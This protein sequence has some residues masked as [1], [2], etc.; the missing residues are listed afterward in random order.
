MQTET[1]KDPKEVAPDK[2][3]ARPDALVAV[4]DENTSSDFP[5][6]AAVGEI[7]HA[8]TAHSP[9]YSNAEQSESNTIDIVFTGC[10]VRV[11][12]DAIQLW[13]WEDRGEDQ[14]IT[15]D[16]VIPLKSPE[17]PDVITVDMS[18]ILEPVSLDIY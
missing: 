2:I 8:L 13:S 10:G 18:K 4:L 14:D 12:R 9:K 6:A 5:R 11:Q 16:V 7:I 15:P 1:T 3:A 17:H